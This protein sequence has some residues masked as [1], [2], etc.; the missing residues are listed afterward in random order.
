MLVRSN[1]FH[2]HKKNFFAKAE[3]KKTMAYFLTHLV[4][5]LIEGIYYLKT[6]IKDQPMSVVL[7]LDGGGTCTLIPSSQYSFP[8]LEPQIY[9]TPT[10][11]TSAFVGRW[12]IV[13]LKVHVTLYGYGSQSNVNISS[14]VS[15]YLDG[16]TK[17]VILLE[18]AF[19][20]TNILLTSVA[21]TADI[22][23]AD[24]QKFPCDN[25]VT[26]VSN[27]ALTGSRISKHSI[28]C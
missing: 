1:L 23:G 4:S 3:R 25:Y 14:G 10:T 6:T 27:L 22:K 9:D 13:G 28:C 7:S 12:K 15:P 11:L 8:N 17:Q 20:Y 16:Q 18:G 2:G 26:I 5:P 19:Y 24:L 21:G